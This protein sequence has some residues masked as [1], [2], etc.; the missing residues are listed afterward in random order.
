MK[1][2]Q[3]RFAKQWLLWVGVW[4]FVAVIFA[5]QLRQSRQSIEQEEQTHLSNLASISV[6]ILTRHFAHT[7]ALLAL[8]LG[9]VAKPG[10]GTPLKSQPSQ[11]KQLI[12]AFP[13]SDI[14]LLLD[15]NGTVTASSREDLVGRNFAHR[16]YFKQAQAKNNPALRIISP[17]FQ[18]TFTDHM[19]ALSRSLSG[20]RGEFAGVAVISLDLPFL[21]HLLAETR[22]AE[23]AWTALVHGDGS[24]VM[25]FPEE[26]KMRVDTVA[27]PGSFF[28]RHRESGKLGNIFSGTLLATG[29]DRL[30]AI[31]TL[32]V[33]KIKLDQAPVVMVSRE[34]AAVFSH[35]WQN[36]RNL[37]ALLFASVV[38][39]GITLLAFQRRSRANW[40]RH[41]Q[42]Q[43]RL[44]R[45]QLL[46][47]SAGNMLLMLDQ[48]QR[49]QIVNAAYAEMLQR[50][51]EAIIATSLQSVTGDLV[52]RQICPYIEVALDGEA[53][54]FIFSWQIAERTFTFQANARPY[55]ESGR[56]TGISLTLHDISSLLVA[57][58]QAR[59][60]SDRARLYLEAV[61]SIVVALNQEGEVSMINAAGCRLLGWSEDELIGK[62]WFETC[63]PQP[64][65][66][67][68][69]FPVYVDLITGATEGVEDFENTVVTRSGE[70]RLI[71]WH[72]V[73]VKDQHGAV[74]GTLSSGRD[75]TDKRASQELLRRLS[76]VV[77]QSHDAVL[78]TNLVPE[79]EYANAAFIERSGYGLDELIGRNPRI[80]S[81]GQNSPAIYAAMWEALAHGESWQGE[82]INQRKNGQIFTESAVISPL[83][84]RDGVITHYMAV[85][86]DI[87]A[88]KK[89]MQELEQHRN[90]LSVLV[91]ER[92][93]ALNLANEE[94][95]ALNLSLESRVL[96]AESASRAKSA[97]LAN[98]SHE[99]RTPL[100]AV[101]GLTQLLQKDVRE[102]RQAD[103]LVKLGD[104]GNHLLGLIND[105]LD[106]SKIE[107]DRI[108]LERADFSLAQVF[109]L[110]SGLV[111]NKLTEQN[112][113]WSTQIDRMIP[114]QINGDAL[115][116]QQVLFNFVSNAIKFTECGGVEMRARLVEQSSD[117]LCIRCEVQDSGIGISGEDQLRL[118]QSFEQADA[119]TTRKYGGTGLGLAISR[120]L[121]HLM[122]GDVGVISSVGSGSTFWFEAR[123]AFAHS[124]PLLHS[125][126]VS[127]IQRRCLVVHENEAI[128]ANVVQHLSALKIR[129]YASRTIKEARV[130]LETAQR[131]GGAYDFLLLSEHLA[132][133]ASPDELL[134]LKPGKLS[135]F[136][137][138]EGSG[139]VSLPAQLSPLM[140]GTIH[141]P[142]DPSL[143]H[144]LLIGD[145]VRQQPGFRD[146]AP[147][148]AAKVEMVKFH[149]AHI[150]LVEDNEINQEIARD[151]L[152]DAG[153]N[154]TLAENGQE[155]VERVAQERYDLILMDMQMPVM[156]G[157]EAT[158][159]IRQ[160]PEGESIPIVAMTAN[161]FSE[162]KALCLA[163]GMNAHVAKP[164]TAEGLFG[165]L[166]HW[167]AVMDTARPTPVV[168]VNR[169]NG[170]KFPAL[171]AVP[172]LDVDQ[173]LKS[174][175]GKTATYKHLLET[176]LKHQQNALPEIRRALAEGD[177][178]EARR[179]VHSTKGS[180]G[181]IG[182]FRVA[183]LAGAIEAAL[184]NG[185]SEL[186]IDS[187]LLVFEASLTEFCQ[188]LRLGLENLTV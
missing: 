40:Q 27:V 10:S 53:L 116:V 19:S 43:A 15:A 130:R 84:Q 89:L 56:Q 156:D 58:S 159:L 181:L 50:P 123:F 26:K 131:A 155:A 170:E 70:R 9:E 117:E 140:A 29:E 112:L 49:H 186:E 45:Y 60:E 28:T 180:G 71:G 144:N 188:A 38:A 164:F 138:S 64:E 115:R 82:L 33:P 108:T 76:Q 79:I 39:S 55:V 109:A 134:P 80:L 3:D 6:D 179:L 175:S 72:N 59:S 147:T 163:A 18:S 25:G 150:L 110:I 136:L 151:L 90:E 148:M 34:N 153:L 12:Q 185:D 141:L 157:L 139:K 65:G 137:L 47:E 183:E 21:G 67:S 146:E 187:L 85:K 24:L 103:R 52:Y 142:F 81:S 31:Q 107:A 93:A 37:L 145:L 152:V 128:G 57:Q 46:V 168:T 171:R 1:L 135:L 62:N 97:F 63:L 149:P 8:W 73:L 162:D 161:A 160:M 88:T 23:D 154:V 173:G 143:V 111:A 104:A 119:S 133:G 68:Q 105:I 132:H 184:R 54:D 102:P 125:Q 61:Q 91:R 74:L 100:N 44:Q 177:R 121:A 114:A 51:V 158:S 94:I 77:E 7:D 122:G 167:L 2:E 66:M 20:A 32:D 118:F 69:V 11:M 5:Y 124:K 182:A 87:S 165:T 178:E 98:M 17:L 176:F 41:E 4:L 14:L 83:R 172:G 86:Q 106:L 129:A 22:Y 42:Q 30:V 99:I 35:W 48:K 126:P 120:K 36:T 166:R 13:G 95:K 169:E 75:I 127:L 16:Y 96:Q 78:I 101:I 113:S 174:V 92:T